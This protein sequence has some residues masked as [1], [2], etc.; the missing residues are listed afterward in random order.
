MSVGQPL[1]LASSIAI[2]TEHLSKSYW[3]KAPDGRGGTR[4]INTHALRDVSF[5]VREGEVFGIIGRNGAGKSTLL[6]VLT[7]IT[8]PS[9]GR[10]I[11]R[12]RVA[13]LLEVGTGMH[14]EMTG[15][16]NIFLNGSLLGMDKDEVRSRLDEIVAFAEVG[17]YLDTP[18]KHYSSGMKLRLAFAVA[19]HLS[20]DVMVVDEVL[21]V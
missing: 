19:A 13:A 6:K 21:A 3:I 15:R 17:H 11:I 7:R 14:P 9:G 10:A 16:E 4:R 1:S 18:I 8:V 12:G 5:E 20:A 2:K